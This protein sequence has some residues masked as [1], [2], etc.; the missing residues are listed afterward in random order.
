M[1]HRTIPYNCGSAICTKS[2]RG[3]DAAR[4]Q[5]FGMKRKEFGGIREKPSEIEEKKKIRNTEN[6][7][8]EIAKV[9]KEERGVP[10]E[11]YGR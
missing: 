8:Y 3:N 11:V 7:K 1:L 10:L 2:E 5:L 4:D 9:R 6:G